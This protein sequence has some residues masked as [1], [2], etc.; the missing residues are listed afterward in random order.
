M[1]KYTKNDAIYSMF[2]IKRCFFREKKKYTKKK[3][4]KFEK[5][6]VIRAIAIFFRFLQNEN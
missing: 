6:N 5:K 2:R 4:E 3:K 1:K